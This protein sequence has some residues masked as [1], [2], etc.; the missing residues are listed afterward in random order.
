MKQVLW[1]TRTV[2]FVLLAL[3]ASPTTFVSAQEP[4]ADAQAPPADDQAEPVAPEATQTA[5]TPGVTDPSGCKG[6]EEKPCRKNNNCYWII[7]SEPDKSG[8][9]KPPYCHKR[10][11]TKKKATDSNTPQGTAAPEQTAPAAQPEAAPD[12]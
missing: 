3:V 6:L 7:P 12:P 5:P 2:A 11:Q 10:G 9:V 4:P 8:N 1:A